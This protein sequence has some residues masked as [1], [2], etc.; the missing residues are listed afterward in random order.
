MTK[1]SIVIVPGSFAA[2]GIYQDL[3]D[4]LRAKGFPAL[5]IDLLSSQK[6]LGLEPATMQ[7]D[8]KHIRAVAET[9]IGQGKEVVV[10]CHVRLPR[11]RN[12]HSRYGPAN[13]AICNRA[14]EA[15]PRPK[16]LPV[17]W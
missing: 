15:T 16:A 8:A 7:D 6:R 4:R 12:T 1:P 2:Q 9:L 5:A 11:F 14:T 3:V 17:S 13:A 10:L